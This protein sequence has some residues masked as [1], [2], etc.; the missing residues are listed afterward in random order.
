MWEV[1]DLVRGCFG[2]GWRGV[3]VGRVGDEVLRRGGLS[4]DSAS[5][6]AELTV[7]GQP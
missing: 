3:A 7:D 6:L 1:R 4:A 5:V 2:G